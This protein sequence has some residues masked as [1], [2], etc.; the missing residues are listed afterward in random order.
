MPK[1]FADL[2]D[3]FPREQRER[4]ATRRDDI[5]REISLKQLRRA[6][7]LTQQELAN[8]VGATREMVAVLLGE[9]R[10]EGII[11]TS[12]HKVL[13]RDIKRLQEIAGP[14]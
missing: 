1:R 13:V 12:H 8:M 6:L 14:K 3:R 10:S 7:R 11:H 4:I 2:L 9:L 5:L